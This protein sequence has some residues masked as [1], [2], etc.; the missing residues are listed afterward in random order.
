MARLEIRDPAN[1]VILNSDDIHLGLVRSGY[2]PLSRSIER[3]VRWELN[4]PRFYPSGILDLVRGVSVPSSTP[5]VFIR[6]KGVLQNIER[7]GGVSTYWYA[8]TTP[9]TMFYAFDKMSDRGG[10]AKLQLFDA[11][12]VITLDSDQTFLNIKGSRTP[13]PPIG[14]Q[15][16]VYSGGAS[17]D[18][19]SSG[20]VYQASTFCEFSVN[21]GIPC[22][23]AFPWAR[24]MFHSDRNGNGLYGA[25]EGCYGRGNELVFSAATEAGC[26]INDVARGTAGIGRFTDIPADRIP[27]A[28]YI[29][30][31][32]YPFPYSV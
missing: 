8:H 1:R 14:P 25:R 24:S 16:Y 3:M 26:H 20:H 6:G 9:N 13:P 27:T 28:I 5:L 21:V 4:D 12:A 29:D 2:L 18:E 17:W 10:G 15:G 7:A 19:P 31:R 32:D 11:S 22:A 30:T 23:A